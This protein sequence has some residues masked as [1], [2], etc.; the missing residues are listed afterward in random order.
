M[1]RIEISPNISVTGPAQVTAFSFFLSFRD[2]WAMKRKRDVRLLLSGYVLYPSATLT[3]WM[4]FSVIRGVKEVPINVLY[5]IT[6]PSR[7]ALSSF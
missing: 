5:V 4:H 3:V 1:G 2:K 7:A 6:R